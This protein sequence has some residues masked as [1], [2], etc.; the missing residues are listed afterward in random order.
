MRWC[1]AFRSMPWWLLWAGGQAASVQ[2]LGDDQ[3]LLPLSTVADLVRRCG[4]L[5]AVM[6][7]EPS[8]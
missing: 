8:P 2:G 5:V 7:A 3:S 1:L 6:P 4:S